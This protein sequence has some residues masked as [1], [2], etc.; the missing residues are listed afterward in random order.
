MDIVWFKR[1]LRVHDHAP[2]AAACASGQP[3]LPLYIL[4]PG[5][6]QQPDA[7]GRHHAML[8][9]A[10]ADLDRSLSARGAR[11]VVR[12]G[13]AVDVLHDLH[14]AH[15]ISAIHAH[16]ETGNL[17][18]FARDRAVR[19]WARAAGVPLTEAQQHGVWR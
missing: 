6:W 17:W 8:F 10:L 9:E 1:D 16:Q 14:A 2:L 11:L 19:R 5:L 13:E 15:G 3:V 4:E 7:S 12:V 18:S